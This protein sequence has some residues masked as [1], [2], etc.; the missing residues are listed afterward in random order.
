MP[1]WIPLIKVALP[2]LAPIFSAL[3]VLTKKKS[4]RADA[5]VNQ[6]ISELQEAVKS[7]DERIT[8]LAR[9]FEAAMAATRSIQLPDQGRTLRPPLFH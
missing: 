8:A 2:Y 3:P 9:T 5:V 4:D 7:N 1:A 6:Q